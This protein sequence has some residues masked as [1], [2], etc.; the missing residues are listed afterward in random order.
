MSRAPGLILKEING[1]R[2]GP[3]GLKA[4]PTLSSF[5]ELKS[6]GST[7]CGAWIYSGIMAPTK[8]EE[9][10]GGHNHAANRSGDNWVSL[11][12]GFAWP[13]NRRVLY[14][15]ASA[16]LR[17]NRGR[18]RPASPAIRHT[19]RPRIRPLGPAAEEMDRP[20]RARTSLPRKRPTRPRSPTASGVENARRR[21]PLHH[22]SRR[23]RVALS[24]RS[25]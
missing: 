2:W 19:R 7:A 12:W 9:R 22:A 5:A 15:R 13:A 10:I 3:G 4:G 11:G 17:A 14:N 18:R 24:S 16:D 1:Y 25:A 21:Q 6:D 20:R 8:D 23:Q